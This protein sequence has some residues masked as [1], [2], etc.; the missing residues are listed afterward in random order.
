MVHSTGCAESGKCFANGCC[1]GGSGETD[2]RVRQTHWEFPRSIPLRRSCS[3]P[4]WNPNRRTETRDHFCSRSDG[5]NV[6]ATSMPSGEMNRLTVWPHGSFVFLTGFVSRSTVYWGTTA[7]STQFVS[8][9]QLSAQVATADISSAGTTAITVQT[10]APGGGTSNSL[11][12]EVDSAAPGSTPPTFGSSTARVAA[13]ST[14]SF[15]V[16]LPSK[17]TS[18]SVTCL[19]L[20]TG[21]TCSYS[22]TTNTVTIATT[23]ATPAGTYQITAVFTELCPAQPLVLC[24]CQFSCYRS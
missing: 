12:F 2:G 4:Q 5:V 23:L 19:N 11:Q 20:P 22:S 10:P 17:A 15:P 8:A 14:A 9:T 1:G 13:G 6:T 24:C 18:V 16:T 21:A 7:L 3:G